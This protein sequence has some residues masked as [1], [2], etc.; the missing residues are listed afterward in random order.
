MRGHDRPPIVLDAPKHSQSTPMPA[1]TT[2]GHDDY[3]RLTD[4][5]AQRLAD[6]DKETQS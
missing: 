6:H 5:G 4:E 3:Y 2:T 1:P